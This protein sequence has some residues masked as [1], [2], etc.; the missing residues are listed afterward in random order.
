MED[1]YYAGGL[2]AVMAALGDKLHRD[3]VTVSG[4]TVADNI[5]G[6][7]NYNREVIGA[8][9]QPFKKEN[10]LAVLYGNLCP[11]GAVIK[12]SAAT[13]AL[14]KHRGRAVVFESNEELHRLVEDPNL[15]VDE[16]C[17]LVLKGAGPRGYPGMPEVGNFPLPKK[18]LQK[19]VTDMVRISDARM[20][21][22][23]FGTVVLHVTPEAAVLGPLAAV[24]DGD[25][26]AL[27]V[28]G[29][30][31]D[32]LV[33]DDE[34]QARLARRAP[35]VPAYTRG[36]GAM[37]LEHVTSAA[38]G[39]DFDFL[40]KVPGEPAQSEPHGLLSGWIGGW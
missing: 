25:E 17:I 15:D 39:C 31:L 30:T 38:E 6:A 23:A 18:I 20:S 4:K 36:Y 5:K 7:Q 40:Q 37:Y 22:T 21:G 3:H 24:E 12:P 10:A 29:R 32:L 19:G 35:R 13:P 33:P 9:S 2:P 14:L 8:L 27:D 11:D 28:E 1:F 16:N 26:I 34:I